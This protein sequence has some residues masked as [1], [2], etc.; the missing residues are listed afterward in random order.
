MAWCEVFVVFVRLVPK[1]ECFY[2][3]EVYCRV[4]SMHGW[5]DGWVDVYKIVNG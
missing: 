1:N 4:N 3:E 5:S 2:T